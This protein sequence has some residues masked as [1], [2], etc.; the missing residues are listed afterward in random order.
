MK[1]KYVLIIIPISLRRIGHWNLAKIKKSIH[2]KYFTGITKC[3]ENW[4][5]SRPLANNATGYSI[6]ITAQ[7]AIHFL[8]IITA[9]KSI[10]YQ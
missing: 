4:L 5:K 3:C 7:K 8:I 9:E 6:S 1:I 10:E 2:I